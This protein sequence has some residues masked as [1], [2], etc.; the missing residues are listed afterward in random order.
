MLKKM[1][2]PTLLGGLMVLFGLS[3]VLIGFGSG[4]QASDDPTPT[5]APLPDPVQDDLDLDVVSAIDL[6]EYPDVP[7]ISAYAQQVYL[8]GLA[9]GSNP[10]TFIKVGDC[11]TDNPFFLIPLGEGDYDLGEYT[12]LQPLI[13]Q[14]IDGDLNSFSRKSQAAAGGFNASSIRDSLWAN[15]EFCEPGETPLGCEMRLMQPSIALIMFGTNDVFYL[16][17]AQFDFFLRSIVVETVRNGALPVLST[18]PH[19]PEFPEKSMLYNQIVVQIAQD[20]DLPLI[21]LWRALVDLPNQGVDPEETT[22]MTTPPGGAV[23]YFIDE[24][25]Q[26]GFTVRNLLTLQTLEAVLQATVSE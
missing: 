9:Q 21:N 2:I 16:T 1:L 6:Y 5:L 8:Q 12:A 13:D 10:H 19:R 24:N 18:F 15:P 17:E 7:T 23:C 26:A 25:L 11:M 14:F 20:Y 4:V 3:G 22:H